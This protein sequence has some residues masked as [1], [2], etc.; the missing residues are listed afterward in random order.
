MRA[1]SSSSRKSGAEPLAV[2]VGDRG[3]QAEHQLLLAHL[4]AEHADALLV[5]DG[6][7]LGDVQREARFA[8]RRPGR[9]DHEVALL[10]A[11]R[12][13]VEVPEPGPDAADLAPMRVQVVEPVVGVV[14]EA[15]EQRE[16]GGD[17]TLADCEQL[18]LGAVDR[19]LDFGRVLVAD[20]GDP[21]RGA[22]QVP[23]HR[24]AL[25]DSRVLRRVDGRRRGVRQGAEVGAPADRF[26]VLVALERL[27]DR[28]DV[29]RLAPFEQ[30]QDHRVDLGMGLAV[31]VLGLEELGDL[32]DRV[33]VDEDRAEHGLL[34]LDGLRRKAVDHSA[35]R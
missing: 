22:D 31:E 24:L 27:G 14:E 2:D 4:E 21:A 7:V 34:G 32:D 30:V 11:R 8:D 5:V 23:Q 26:Q 20:A 33:A 17:T 18:G 3:Q 28:D 9:E 13:R 1:K 15:A 12:E 16:A 10:E 25:D 35:Q 19:L 6:G 29:N